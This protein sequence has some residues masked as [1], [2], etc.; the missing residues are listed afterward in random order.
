M[1]AVERFWNKVQKSS[2][3]WLWTGTIL[4]DGYG[5]FDRRRAHRV[6]WELTNGPI[7][8][9]QLILHRCDNPPCVRP[10][11]LFLGTHAENMADMTSK[12]RGLTGS[13]SWLSKHG[14]RAKPGEAHHMAKLTT[15]QVAEIRELYEPN[16]HRRPSAVSQRALAERF[17][18]TQQTISRA[19][20][21]QRWGPK[22]KV[23][24]KPLALGPSLSDETVRMIRKR[25]ALGDTSQQALADELGLSQSHVGRIV[26]GISR[27]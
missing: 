14:Q 15:E 25:Y 6:A 13:R 2:G 9:G 27:A 16:P 7:P 23:R 19:L 21:G 17:G 1:T 8:K 4:H 26:R 20:R 12:G 3:C 18:V 10:D 22:A 24:T 11:H 5:Q